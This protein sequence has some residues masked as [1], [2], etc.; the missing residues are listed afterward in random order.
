MKIV[1]VWAGHVYANLDHFWFLD[2]Q[3]LHLRDILHLSEQLLDVVRPRVA[4][5]HALNLSPLVVGARVWSFA[6]E[7]LPHSVAHGHVEWHLLLVV[8]ESG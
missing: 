8:S 4:D 2:L 7:E 6:P 1:A 5:N 3:W